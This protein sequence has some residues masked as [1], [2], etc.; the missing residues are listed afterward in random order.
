M[1]ERHVAFTR[2]MAAHQSPEAMEAL[3]S[4]IRE[5]G[6]VIPVVCAECAKRL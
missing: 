5:V 6:P 3:C 1:V 4:A 2:R